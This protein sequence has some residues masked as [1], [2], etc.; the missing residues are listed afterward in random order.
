YAEYLEKSEKLLE[1][2]RR[3]QQEAQ[4]KKQPPAPVPGKAK[5][6]TKKTAPSTGKKRKIEEIEHKINQ[7][8]KKKES[9][10]TVMANEDFYKKSSEETTG[11]L[12]T[13]HTA[14]REL[15][16]LFAEWERHCS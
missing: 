8:E 10:E 7:L 4:Q 1:E 12:E 9:L 13:Y 11:T 5:P 15:E 3:K 2:E 16:A 6:D 14:C